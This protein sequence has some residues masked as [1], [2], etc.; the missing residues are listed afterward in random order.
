[1][2]INA[3]DNDGKTPLHYA[4]RKNNQD[5][6]DILLDAG[7]VIDVEKFAPLFLRRKNAIES[8][9]VMEEDV[10]KKRAEAERIFYY[11]L[12]PLSII[13][14][15]IGLLYFVQHIL[16]KRDD[17]AAK[18]TRECEE[19]EKKIASIKSGQGRFKSEWLWYDNLSAKNK[20]KFDLAIQEELKRQEEKRQTNIVPNIINRLDKTLCHLRE[21][22]NQQLS[23]TDRVAM[24]CLGDLAADNSHTWCAKAN[25]W[26]KKIA[27]KGAFVD[28]SFAGRI[29][30][31]CKAIDEGCDAIKDPNTVVAPE[32][33]RAFEAKVQEIRIFF[34]SLQDRFENVPAHSRQNAAIDKIQQGLSDI[35][36]AKRKEAEYYLDESLE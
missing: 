3:K 7:A 29:H 26:T 23:E 11:I 5:A 16:G 25:A 15:P 24:Q 36:E 12:L 28:L 8:I 1:V 17:G 32:Q 13:I 14:P 20:S 2:N 33:R 6:I 9:P 30:S 35:V 4:E 22:Q 10:K 27:W 21:Q 19:I 18:L 34:A 31:F